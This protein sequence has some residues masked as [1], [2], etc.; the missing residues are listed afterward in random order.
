MKRSLEEAT[1]LAKEIFK[2]ALDDSR[3]ENIFEKLKA[4]AG[5]SRSSD[6]FLNS[7]LESIKVYGNNYYYLKAKK[8]IKDDKIADLMMENTKELPVELE[9]IGKLLI[10]MLMSPKNI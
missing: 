9:K 7:L 10:E 5:G 1:R 4:I 6:K 2:K 8:I 3:H